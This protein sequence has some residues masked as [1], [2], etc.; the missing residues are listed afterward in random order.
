MARREQKIHATMV[1]KEYLDDKLAYLRG[2]LVV[3][4]NQKVTELVK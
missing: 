2:D 1:T 3:F 4:V